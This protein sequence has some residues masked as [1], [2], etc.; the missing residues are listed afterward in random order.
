MVQIKTPLFV[1]GRA[2]GGTGR[3]GRTFRGTDLLGRTLRHHS[4]RARRAILTYHQMQNAFTRHRYYRKKHSHI[5]I[6]LVRSQ[7]F[8]E[9]LDCIQGE[10][11]VM[12]KL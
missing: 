7:R 6:R 1:T 12:H 11:L 9:F 2:P 3:A 5:I 8:M 10:E 4:R